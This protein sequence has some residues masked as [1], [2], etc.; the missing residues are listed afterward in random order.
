MSSGPVAVSFD[1]AIASLSSV[2]LNRLLYSSVF[3]EVKLSLIF[4]SCFFLCFETSLNNS[5]MRN[6]PKQF[7]KCICYLFL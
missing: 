1:T 4:S 6:Y 5:E 2:I 7:R 3:E